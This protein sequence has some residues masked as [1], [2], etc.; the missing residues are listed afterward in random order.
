MSDTGDTFN[1][2]K[3]AVNDHADK[4]EGVVGKVADA[5]KKATGGSHDDKIDKG[6]GAATDYLRKRAQ[7]NKKDKGQE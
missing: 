5:A 3:K 2:L 1:R 6:A 7:E 4:A